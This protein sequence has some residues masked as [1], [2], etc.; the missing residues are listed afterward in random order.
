VRSADLPGVAAV[1]RLLQPATDVGVL[2][3]F[4]LVLTL[5]LVAGWW[6]R[7]RPEW[8]LVLVGLGLLLLGAMG[9]RAAH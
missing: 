6:L 2:A 5:L 1:S 8:R 4:A 9:I 7:R 3:Q